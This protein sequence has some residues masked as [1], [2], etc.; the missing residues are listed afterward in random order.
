VL[1][2]AENRIRLVLLDDHDLLRVSLARFLGSEPGLEIA[3]ECGTSSEALR[4]LTSSEVDIVLLDFDLEAESRREFILA[5]RQAGYQG[6]F[7]IIAGKL[8]VPAA[9]MALKLGV[10]GIF[11]KSETPERLVHAVK[12]VAGGE[13]WIEPKVTQMLADQL[14][15]QQ[16]PSTGWDQSTLERRERNV[17]LGILAGMTNRKIGE[18][19]DLSESAVKNVVQRLFRRAGVKTRGQLVRVALEGSLNAGRYLVH[20]SN[21]RDRRIR[22]DGSPATSN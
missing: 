13:A 6:H 2:A 14:S 20:K 17:L 3:G 11:L 10:S 8:E 9:A 19:L 5:A 1:G 7:V 15:G 18:R 4:I 22:M 12:L 16:L 21:G